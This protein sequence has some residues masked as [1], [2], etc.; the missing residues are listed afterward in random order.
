MSSEKPPVVPASIGD[1]YTPRSR[2]G[3]SVRPVTLL[4]S[5]AAFFRGWT[6]KCKAAAMAEIA[7]DLVE[8]W[9]P[10]V[11]VCNPTTA[12]SFTV[13]STSTHLPHSCGLNSTHTSMTHP[14]TQ[15]ITQLQYLLPNLVHVKV[16]NPQHSPRL[17]WFA[18][19]EVGI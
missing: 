19:V 12:S 8:T 13:F 4:A 7:P 6:R 1:L 11:S 16:A 2:S 5:T 3:L 18:A 9:P 10:A 15:R 14:G 17:A